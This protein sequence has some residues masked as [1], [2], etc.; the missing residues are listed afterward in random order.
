MLK[1]IIAVAVLAV[2]CIAS[3]SQLPDYPFIHASGNGMVYVAPDVGEVDFEISAQQ[4]DPEAAR[5]VVEA[6]IAEVRALVAALGLPEADVEI[7]DVRKEMR[8]GERTSAGAA[9]YD[10]KCGVHIKVSDL[11][12]WKA[13][14]APLVD[15]PNVDGFMTG[16]DTS[17]RE[18]VE[19]ELMGEAIKAAR[20]KAEA[21]AAGFGR[22]LGAVAGVSPGDLKNVTRAMGMAAAEP[23]RFTRTPEGRNQYDRDALLMIALMK[24]SQSVDV[25]FRIK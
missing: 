7:R 19:V 2:P 18:Q 15:M 9:M 25:I 22:K 5:K 11:L 8:K 23:T 3:A 24:M 1:K 20:R 4:E 13:L 12:K 17:K 6:R 21:M 16:F 10:I 14:V